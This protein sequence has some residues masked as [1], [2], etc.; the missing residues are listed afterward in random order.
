MGHYS[1]DWVRKFYNE[2]GMK[3]WNRWEESPVEQIKFFVH[4]HHLKNH[5]CPTDRVL[6]IGAGAGR[7][8]QQLAK[9]TDHIVVAD[10][11]PV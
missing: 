9:I 8:T 6:E 3:E 11:S 10:I 7:F 4:L 5:V 1:A 2:Y